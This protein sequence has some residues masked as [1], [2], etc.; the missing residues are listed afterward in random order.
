M[1]FQCWCLE[2]GNRR[3]PHPLSKILISCYW[4]WVQKSSYIRELHLFSS[5]SK[6][7][8]ERWRRSKC[9]WWVKYFS[10]FS[11]SAIMESKCL[12]CC[13]LNRQMVTDKR[14][15]LTLWFRWAA[16]SI[17]THTVLNR[18]DDVSL[19]FTLTN[20]SNWDLLALEPW[21]ASSVTKDAC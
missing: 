19:T 3:H 20:G 7:P 12:S 16:R 9:L 14:R 15:N 10:F 17:W 6:R 1:K 8:D 18:P 5:P 13:N 11:T 21:P 2:A 4:T